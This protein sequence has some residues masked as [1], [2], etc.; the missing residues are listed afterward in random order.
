[1]IKKILHLIKKFLLWRKLK[2]MD[3]FADYT[4]MSSW[5]M[6]PPSFYYTH[7]EEEIAQAKAELRVKFYEKLE[8]LE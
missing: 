7:T 6:F 5:M 1:M 8:Q 2:D 4:G 3:F